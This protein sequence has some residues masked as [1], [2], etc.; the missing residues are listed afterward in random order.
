MFGPEGWEDR[1]AVGKKSGF[2]ISWKFFFRK[3]SEGCLMNQRLESV[4]KE[5]INTSGFPGCQMLKGRERKRIKNRPDD[6]RERRAL[7]PGIKSLIELSS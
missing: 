4:K 5:W 6:R 3:E 1:K 2:K 7:S